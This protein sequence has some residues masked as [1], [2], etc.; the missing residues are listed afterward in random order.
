[1]MYVLVRNLKEYKKS[2]KKWS[3]GVNN[4]IFTPNTKKEIPFNVESLNFHA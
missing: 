2:F 3:Q 4:I 1:M